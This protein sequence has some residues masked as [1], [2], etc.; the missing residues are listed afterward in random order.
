MPG[1]HETDELEEE[2]LMLLDSPFDADD[3]SNSVTANVILSEP[4]SHGVSEARKQ[5]KSKCPVS[6]PVESADEV[7]IGSSERTIR[8]LQMTWERDRSGHAVT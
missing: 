4:V 2:G 8:L 1:F 7:P 6:A 5:A 3:E